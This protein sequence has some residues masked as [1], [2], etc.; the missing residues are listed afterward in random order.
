MT[1]SGFSTNDPTASA[2]EVPAARGAPARMYPKAVD[3]RSGWM[4]TVT[5]H[6]SRAVATASRTAAVKAQASRTTWSAANEPTIAPGVRCSTTAAASAIA[7]AESRG[8]GSASTSPAPSSGS[9]AA[10]ASACATPVT[11]T[12]PPPAIGASR[13]RVCWSRSGRIL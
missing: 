12:V 2:E 8:E 11:T 9:C 10:T 6:P 4:P 13:S 3:G 5:I 7:A 1:A